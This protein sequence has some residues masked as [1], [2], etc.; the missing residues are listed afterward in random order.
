MENI[1][2][3][4][5]CKLDIDG[6][7]L[8]MIFGN[9]VSEANLPC[10]KSSGR[11]FDALI[12]S[13]YFIHKEV[14]TFDENG[15]VEYAPVDSKGNITEIALY[16]HDNLS[17]TPPGTYFVAKRASILF[18]DAFGITTG[19]SILKIDEKIRNSLLEVV[20]KTTTK[21]PECYIF[22]VTYKNLCAAAIRGYE[23][24]IAENGIETFISITG[25]RP[26]DENKLR[27]LK[28]YAGL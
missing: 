12:D 10:H 6:E 1:N 4:F 9:G 20:I 5:N 13:L 16:T 17:N 22:D 14:A 15:T 8:K 24:F 28:T 7:N 18:E 11:S 21:I 27:F 19:I 23:K 2:N 25:N 3:Y 26:V